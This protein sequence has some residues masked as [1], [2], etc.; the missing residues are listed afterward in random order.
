MSNELHTQEVKNALNQA[1]LAYRNG[2]RGETR[3]WASLAAR[4]DPSNEQAWL[5]LAGIA[6]PH[7]SVAYLEK[8]LEINPESSQA[9]KGMEWA[10]R[11]LHTVQMQKEKT[12]PQSTAQRPIYPPA[13]LSAASTQPVAL[14]R[15]Q[16]WFTKWSV[17]IFTFVFLGLCIFSVSGILIY[18]ARDGGVQRAI[19]A[20]AIP[21]VTSTVQSPS[22]TAQPEPSQTPIQVSTATIAVPLASPTETPPFPDETEIPTNTPVVEKV[23]VEATVTPNQV[24]TLTSEP[25]TDTPEPNLPPPPEVQLPDGIEPGER[26]IDVDLSDQ[27][28][29]AYEGTERVNEF[30][31]STGTWQYPTVVGQFEVYVKYRY[32]DMS[33]PGYYLSNVPYVMYFYKG[34]GLHGTYWHENFGTPM[35]HGCVNLRT[36]DAGWL[37]DWSTVGTVVNV[38]D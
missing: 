12:G 2:N 36:D 27:M 17:L 22:A 24:S 15:G 33:G 4:L 37:F 21:N 10:R 25:P 6:S 13:Q 3:R 7:A 35:S 11:R 38:H 16:P 5:I 26:W 1:Y 14:K 18:L 30:L 28:V 31:V 32:A 19:A 23:T 20:I 8:A 34:Y 9:R 29:Y